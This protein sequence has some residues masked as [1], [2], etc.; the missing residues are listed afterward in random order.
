[1]KALVFLITLL[2]SGLAFSNPVISNAKFGHG[3]AT[4]H[5]PLVQT[6][7][8]SGGK[9]V[10]QLCPHVKD[11]YNTTTFEHDG[12][13]P[14]CGMNLIELHPQGVT[15]D[16]KLHAGSGNYFISGGKGHEARLIN[17][18]YHVPRKF[19]ATSR[20]LLVIPGAGRNAWSY[21]DSWIDASEQY[22]V[23]I[24]SPAYAEDDYDFARY[25]LGGIVSNLVFNNQQA[26]ADGKKT[27]QY[28]FKDEELLFDINHDAQS[29]L[30]NDFDRIFDSAIGALA[31]QQSNY[32]I[33]GHSAGG[34]ILHRFAI[35]HPDSKAKRIVAANSGSYTIA[36]R[37]D[38]LPFGLKNSGLSDEHLHR[39]FAKSL[40][41]LVGE[42]D[43][44]SE[45]RG[46]MLHTPTVDKQGLGRLSRSNYFFAQ[47][48]QYAAHIG[49][50]VNW[51]H[52]VVKGVGHDFKQ[53]SN[54]A[55]HYLY[56]H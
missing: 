21:R 2:F 3:H 33:F 51:Q 25:H 46:S 15:R 12:Q 23:L 40:T 24:L 34:Q 14:V 28:R 20:V 49:A 17:V 27:S 4:A 10:C 39:S 7:N 36:N 6:T 41:L 22:N 8:A 55:A 42:L 31:G 38:G 26:L 35:F 13:C 48:A 11:I 9:Y 47:S 53:M 44:E 19:N 16:L 50:R 32:D 30:F 37:E 56:A 1:M 54:A 43:N 52:Q 5:K 18:F 45:T 29:W